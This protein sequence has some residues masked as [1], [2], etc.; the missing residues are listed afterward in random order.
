MIFRAVETHE[1]FLGHPVAR[2][3][4]FAGP[5]GVGKTTALRALSDIP[6]VNTD[7]HSTEAALSGRT[8][9]K[10]A[11]TAAFDYGEFSTEAGERVALLG[12]PGQE[13]FEMMWDRFIPGSTAVVL[14]VFGDTPD[15]GLAD[16]ATWLRALGARKELLRLAVAVSRL[17]AGGEEEGLAPYRALLTRTMPLAPVLGA[18]PRNQDDVRRTVAAALAAPAGILLPS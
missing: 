12:L 11:T 5:F 3:V 7:V 2:H 10:T 18:D 4:V 14:W 8:E 1:I 6:V 15:T 16:C 17:P 13:R 9:G